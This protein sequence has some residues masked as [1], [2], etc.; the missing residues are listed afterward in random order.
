LSSIFLTNPLVF[1]V[2]EKVGIFVF[3]CSA[4]IL[5]THAT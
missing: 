5:Y 2:C 3:I 4:I 1:W